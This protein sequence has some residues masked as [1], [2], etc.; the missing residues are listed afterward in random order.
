MLTRCRRCV[1]PTTRP[2]T[3]FI[4]GVC[5][6][7]RTMDLRVSVDWGA[8]SAELAAL[9]E[10]H[11]RPGAEF[12]CI[13]PSSGGKDSHAQVLTLLKLGAKPLVVT[14]STC[15]LTDIG[16]RNINNLARWATTIEMTPQ[17]DVRAKLNR[18]GLTTVGDISWPEHVSIFTLPF[19]LAVRMGIPLLFYGENP[20]NQYGGPPGTEEARTMTRRWVSEFGGFLGLR[21]VDM[22]GKDGIRESDMLP[23]MPPSAEEIAA[24][25]VEA[26]FLGQYVPWDS[27]ANARMALEC[28]M[29]ADLPSAAN[30]WEWENLDNA[31]TGIHDHGMYRKFGFGRLAAQVSVDVRMGRMTRQQALDLVQARDGLFPY[32][33]AGV[34]LEAILAGIDMS[35]PE[36]WGAINAFTN[37]DLFQEGRGPAPRDL[38]RFP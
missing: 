12:D 20:Q 5:S 16:R 3:A 26:H 29:H 27:W 36:F 30:Y 24:V 19:K 2:D 37:W 9:L 34:P 1:I 15:H 31:Q 14:A 28:G 23:Y 8:R 38:R 35:P 10:R 11:R 18:L 25:G 33:Y 7:C 17:R 4:D 22:I 13:V 21:P 6:A 32:M